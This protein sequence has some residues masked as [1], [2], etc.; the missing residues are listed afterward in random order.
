[1]VLKG[2]SHSVGSMKTKF[3]QLSGSRFR[4]RQSSGRIAIVAHY[5]FGRVRGA[6]VFDAMVRISTTRGLASMKMAFA[7]P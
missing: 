2:T 5:G 3:R 6:E 7:A 4:M 1:M